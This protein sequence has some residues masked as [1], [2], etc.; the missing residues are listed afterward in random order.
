MTKPTSFSHFKLPDGK[1]LTDAS[2][3]EL[4]A[5][6]IIYIAQG[7]KLGPYAENENPSIVYPSAFIKR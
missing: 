3:S 6:A 1:R 5:A 2:M 7:K 4:E